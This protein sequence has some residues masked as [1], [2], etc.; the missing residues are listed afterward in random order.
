MEPVPQ[1]DLIASLHTSDLLDDTEDVAKRIHTRHNSKKRNSQKRNSQKRDSSHRRTSRLSESQQFEVEPPRPSSPTSLSS[2]TSSSSNSIRSPIFTTSS[3]SNNSSNESIHCSPLIMVTRVPCEDKTVPFKRADDVSGLKRSTSGGNH[4]DSRERLIY[5]NHGNGLLNENTTPFNTVNFCFH[6]DQDTGE[7]L[8][9][10][11]IVMGLSRSTSA[12]PAEI[13]RRPRASSNI[14]SS[15]SP[16]TTNTSIGNGSKMLKM[17][18][19]KTGYKMTNAE[20]IPVYRNVF[21]CVACSE[22]VK[23]AKEYN[24]DHIVKIKARALAYFR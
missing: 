9:V 4:A 19:E 17:T 24:T 18:I 5:V 6:C 10:V 16:Y 12:E 20:M 22:E 1:N 11:P 14:S 23:Q 13:V 21:L 3:G 8:L 15:S 2:A 7:N